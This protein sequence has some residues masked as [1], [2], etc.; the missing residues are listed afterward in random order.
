MTTGQQTALDGFVD[1]MKW[2]WIYQ[3]VALDDDCRFAW[4]SLTT[5]V[6][7]NEILDDPVFIAY[8]KEQDRK[9]EVFVLGLTRKQFTDIVF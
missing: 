3:N 4:K 5:S 6:E 9:E 7:R 1:L 2:R 8:C